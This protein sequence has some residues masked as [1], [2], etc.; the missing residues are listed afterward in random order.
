[1]RRRGAF[2]LIELMVVVV[3]IGL[4][5]AVAIP[6]LI[7]ARERRGGKPRPAAPTMA[8]AAPV[9]SAARPIAVERA[10]LR[11]ALTTEPYVEDQGVR[12]RFVARFDVTHLVR[13]QDRALD[14][15]WAFPQGI[16]EARD[17]ALWLDGVEPPDAEFSLEGVRWSGVVTPGAP[18]TARLTYTVVGRDALTFD[19]AGEGRAGAVRLEV[20]LDGDPE[21]VVPVEALQPTD[22]GPG[23]LRWA[24]EGLITDRVVKLE[25]PA[26]TSPLGRLVLLCQLAGL[27][28]L[29]FGAGLW[30]LGEGYRPGH[31][32]DFHT[33]EFAL[34]AASYALFFAVF[35][36][37]AHERGDALLALGMAAPV[38]LPLL[39]LQLSRLLDTRFALTRGLPLCLATLTFVVACAYLDAQRPFIIIGAVTGVVAG[40]TITFRG[41]SAG[42][43]W[44]VAQAARARAATTS[45]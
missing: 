20:A 40:V 28:V 39:V 24:L 34:L 32:D 1:M 13:P 42:R 29:L 45:A 33:F 18:L 38:S 19:V 7:E 41:W 37:I 22:R 12:T 43:A 31:L 36:T 44:H 11:V 26:G 27:S 35:A 16:T 6:L 5:A 14:L 10:D 25:L 9:V 8:V 17:V 3:F 23:R 15:R 21:V 2:T 4:I 30:Y